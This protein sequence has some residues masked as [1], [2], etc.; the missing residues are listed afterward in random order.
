M[1]L[2]VAPLRDSDSRWVREQLPPGE[3]V[4]WEQ[5]SNADQA[6]ALRVAR[7]VVSELGDVAT[8]PVISAALMHDVGK[9]QSGYGTFGRVFATV[10]GHLGLSLRRVRTYMNHNE[11]GSQMLARAGSD[12]LTIAWAREHE[13]PRSQWTIDATIANALYAADDE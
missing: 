7:A 13:L 11:L 9:L 3:W 10:A 2:H 6:H 8:H 4:L 1:S 12:P 5:M